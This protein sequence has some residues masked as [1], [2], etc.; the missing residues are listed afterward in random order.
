[1]ADELEAHMP[2]H[3]PIDAARVIG[4]VSTVEE[5]R[6]TLPAGWHARLPDNVTATSAFGSYVVTYRQDGRD[7]LISSHVS[8]ARGIEPKEHIGALIA[9]LRTMGKN[10]VPFIVIDHS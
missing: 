8:G 6:I 1:M 9:W 7:L 4:P 10:R 3:M 2:R 5:S